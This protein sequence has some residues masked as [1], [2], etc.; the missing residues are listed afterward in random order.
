MESRTI[1]DGPLK[2]VVFSILPFA[3]AG[4]QRWAEAQ[5]HEIALLVTTPGPASRRNTAYLEIIKHAP[6][7]QQIVVST[8]M[9]RLAPYITS[10]EPDLIVSFTFPYLIPPELVEIPKHG[11]VN[12]HPT[13]LPKYRG[14]NPLRVIYDG[15]S[16]IG[17]TLHW[18]APGFDTGNILSQHAWQAPEEA[19]FEQMFG[20]VGQTA[21]AALAEGVPL[22]VAGDPGREQNDEEATYAARFGADDLVLDLASPAWLIKRQIGALR[23]GSQIPHVSVDNQY[24]P[25]LEFEVLESAGD[26]ATAGE[27]TS[28]NGSQ[29]TVQT[30]NVPVLL[31]IG[32][33]RDTWPALQDS[34]V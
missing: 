19:T 26:S 4:I 12:L 1:T 31:T 33:G 5:G 11:A 32:D 10:L 14:P 23:A 34:P 16:E 20:M 24:Y 18:T 21:A 15:E 9:K 3:F 25:I 13:L 7:Q 27:I 29:I 2:I 22:A 6:P 8:K 30:G 17:A 28:R